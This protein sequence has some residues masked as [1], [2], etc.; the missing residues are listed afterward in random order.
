MGRLG[1]GRTGNKQTSP[2]APRVLIFFFCRT[3]VV[4]FCL[5]L[6]ITFTFQL[7][8]HELSRSVTLWT[9][10][11]H[12]PPGDAKVYGHTTAAI[13]DTEYTPPPPGTSKVCLAGENPTLSV[14][15][16]CRAARVYG[17]GT[18][19]VD[20]MSTL[21]STT[22]M[23]AISRPLPHPVQALLRIAHRAQHSRCSHRSSSD[24]G[25]MCG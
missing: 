1:T 7:G 2:P 20:V 12:S 18:T 3:S 5:C 9:S 14:P 11:G 17:H 6:A 21:Q 8:S 24:I 16:H 23:H 13:H 15:Q 19:A 25:C 4:A 10:R 22:A